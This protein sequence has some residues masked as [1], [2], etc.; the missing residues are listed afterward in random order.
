MRPIFKS[1]FHLAPQGA[2]THTRTGIDNYT[3]AIVPTKIVTP[4]SW[5][6]SINVRKKILIVTIAQFGLYFMRQP[7]CLKNSPAW[8]QACVH[9]HKVIFNVQQALRTQPCQQLKSVWRIKN[10]MECIAMM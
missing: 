10:V 3:Q 4:M 8:Q 2:D 6:I 9:Q 1:K 7:L 5:I